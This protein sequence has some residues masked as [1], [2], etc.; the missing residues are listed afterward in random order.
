MLKR[1]TDFRGR[2]LLREM[3]TM[4][5][6]LVLIRPGATWTLAKLPRWSPFSLLLRLDRNIAGVLRVIRRMDRKT[7]EP[8]KSL[9]DQP[10][11]VRLNS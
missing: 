1:T 7:S 10:S 6:D 3:I 9:E 8:A 2:I 4:H 5:G 11:W